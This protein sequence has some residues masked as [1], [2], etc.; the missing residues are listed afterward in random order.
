MTVEEAAQALGQHPATI[1]RW[2]KQERIYAVKPY[3][4]DAIGYRIPVERMIRSFRE[5]GLTDRAEKVEAYLA[6]QA[7]R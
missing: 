1:R 4:S 2:I 5:V 6:M 3:E 7:K